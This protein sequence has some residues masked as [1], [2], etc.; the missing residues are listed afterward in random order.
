MHAARAQPEE[1][2]LANQQPGRLLLRER[3]SQRT[4]LLPGARAHRVSVGRSTAQQRGCVSDDTTAA[5]LPSSVMNAWRFMGAPSSGLGSDITTPL[6][7]GA[8]VHHSKNCA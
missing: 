8:V 1:M 3:A 6:R 5:A 4:A 2:P 7:K